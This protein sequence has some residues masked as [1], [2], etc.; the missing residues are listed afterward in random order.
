[1][2]ITFK[3]KNNVRKLIHKFYLLRGMMSKNLLLMVYRTLVESLI[4]YGII[5]W[6]GLYNNALR[7]LNVIQNF[8][9]KVIYNKNKHYPTAL[10]YNEDIFNVR[11]LYILE[12]C[13]YV[14]KEKKIKNY[15]NHQ[16]ETRN[17][18]QK[19]LQIPM[20]YRDINQRFLS[21]LGP[22]FYNL[23]P[24][25]IRK[26]KNRKKFKNKCRAYVVEKYTE[27]INIL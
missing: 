18:T 20:S 13:L 26:I 23:L 3:L 8:I 15:V 1:M 21:Y 12:I 24:I 5:V 10:L 16:Y 22:K 17:K 9:L 27:F 7:Q 25:S 19:N 6:G 14:H 11:S 4:R 2:G